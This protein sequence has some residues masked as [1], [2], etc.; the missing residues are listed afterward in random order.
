MKKT[1]ISKKILGMMLIL[2]ILISSFTN[3]IFAATSIGSAFLQQI[4]ISR[5]ALKILQRR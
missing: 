3:I 5:F 1:I 2:I 4:R